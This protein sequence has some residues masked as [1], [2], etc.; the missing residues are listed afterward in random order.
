MTILATF[1]AEAVNYPSMT[2][3]LREA[4]F[5]SSNPP[6]PLPPP[7]HQLDDSD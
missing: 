3:Y 4:I 7:N 1:G 6:D 5:T 2:R